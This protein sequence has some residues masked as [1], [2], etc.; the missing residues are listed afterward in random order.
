MSELAK[1]TSMEPDNGQYRT[2]SA[3]Y[4]ERLVFVDTG[5]VEAGSVT[6]TRS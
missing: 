4:I 2:I 1:K 6:S 3:L 5:Y